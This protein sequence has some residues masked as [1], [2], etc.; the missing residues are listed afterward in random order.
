MMKLPQEQ[1]SILQKNIKLAFDNDYE[2]E[3]IFKSNKIQANGFQRMLTYLY[4][5]YDFKDDINRKQL[6]VSMNQFRLSIFG[7]NEILSYC[8]YQR[9]H[10]D[11]SILIR[12]NRVDKLDVS[13][14]DFRINL[15]NEETITNENEI[16]SF[17]KGLKSAL[18]NFRYKER[19][20]F[21]DKKKTHRIDMTIVKQSNEKKRSL[22]ESGTLTNN[23][24]L[25]VEI[26]YLNKSTSSPDDCLG[27]MLL[28]TNE[29]LKKNLNQEFIL[30]NREITTIKMEYVNLIDSK[31]TIDD[32]EKSSYKYVLGYK[33]I[34]LVRKNLLE[35]DVDGNAEKNQL[36]LE[37]TGRFQLF[38]NEFTKLSGS[39]VADQ[40]NANS[41]ENTGILLE[42]F[43]Q[44]LLDG[45]DSDSSNADQYVLQETTE[46]NKFTLELFPSSTGASCLKYIKTLPLGAQVGPSTKKPFANN[47]SPEPSGDI[48]PI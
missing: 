16:K 12:K 40:D 19:W 6:D 18:K 31:V 4:N 7:Q 44:I 15:N 23:E 43:G 17:H 1:K 24:H 33:P 39:G 11:K 2:F 14:Y 22:A 8:K 13:D 26:E 10:I 45:T 30:S 20:T 42:N 38:E 28:T 32:V 21:V 9:V 46:V 48:T 36:L 5:H 25:E 35:D 41:V 3:I 37:E 34:T 29:L 47:L 27:E